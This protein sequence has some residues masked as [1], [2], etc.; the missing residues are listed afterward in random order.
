MTW[1]KISNSNTVS[2]TSAFSTELFS[3]QPHGYNIIY[4]ISHPGNKMYAVRLRSHAT[5]S[6]YEMSV[7]DALSVCLSASSLL[8]EQ[9]KS[10]MFVTEVPL[11]YVCVF[12]F[13]CFFCFV[14][15]AVPLREETDM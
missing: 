1:H 7:F 11:L 12:L 6:T 3:N 13:L 10:C 2:D 4:I 15:F 14:V 5:V 8:S 9:K